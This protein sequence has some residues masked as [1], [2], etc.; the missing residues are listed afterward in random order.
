MFENNAKK[1][2]PS[3]HKY[4]MLPKYLYT[5]GSEVTLLFTILTQLDD[6]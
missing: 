1:I 6:C 3:I 5:M 2:F 4:F